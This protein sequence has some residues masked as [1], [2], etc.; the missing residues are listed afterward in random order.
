MR[1][2][3]SILA[4]VAP[5]CVAAAPWRRASQNLT[6]DILVLQFADVLEQLET[7]FYSEALAKF[8]ESD[9]TAAGFPSAQLAIQQFMSIQSDEATHSRLLEGAIMALGSTPVANCTFNFSEVLT[10]VNTMVNVARI[11]ENIGVA[12]YLGAAHFITNPGILTTAGTIA[13][14][15]ARHQTILNILSSGSAIPQAFDLAF[16]PNEVLALAG[17]FISGCKIGLHS[18]Q[19]L[20]IT[21]NG[22][23]GPGTLLT[24]SSPALNAS[25][26]GLFC[27]MMVGGF[28]VTLPFP[29]S[30]CVVPQGLNGPVALWITSDSQPLTNS[31]VDRAVDTQVAGPAVA[32]ID[33]QPQLLGQLARNPQGTPP[34]TVTTVNLDQATSII[35]N[36]NSMS[37]PTPMSTTYPSW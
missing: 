14:V 34:S 1:F 4:L 17:P 21:N 32:F 9:F 12:A 25:T 29:I 23:V 7:N 22:T 15:E 28:A 11:V 10:D 8:Q 33:T 20:T 6:Q 5:L 37:T 36:A 30:E 13:T 19:P 16:T 18:N 31:P 3:T 2:A 35:N 27:Q 26:D 24:F